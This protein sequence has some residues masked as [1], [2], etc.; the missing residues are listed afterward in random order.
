MHLEVNDES[1]NINVIFT[2][3]RTFVSRPIARDKLVIV[4]LLRTSQNRICQ[5]CD[6]LKIRFVILVVL[7]FRSGSSGESK[8]FSF[9]VFSVMTAVNE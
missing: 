7:K 9:T 3:M 4:N 6:E 8:S 2:N 5:Q 1:I